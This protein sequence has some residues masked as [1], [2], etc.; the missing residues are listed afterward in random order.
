MHLTFLSDMK[1]ITLEE[2]LT[3]EYGPMGHLEG[4]GLSRNAK[5]Q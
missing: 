2:L 1:T 5:R 3:K 4:I